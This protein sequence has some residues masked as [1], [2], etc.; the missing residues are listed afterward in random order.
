MIRSECVGIP[1]NEVLNSLY[2]GIKLLLLQPLLLLWFMFIFFDV[3]AL[4]KF[5]IQLWFRTLDFISEVVRLFRSFSFHPFFHPRHTFGILLT[6]AYLLAKKTFL[7]SVSLDVSLFSPTNA[8]CINFVYF[9][10]MILI[11]STFYVH[12]NIGSRTKCNRTR[13]VKLANLPNL[14]PSKR[15]VTSKR[16]LH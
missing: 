12:D 6:S 5:H 8:I 1:E 9:S 3:V 11:Y 2:Y 15:S 4:V 7:V 14:M 13:N 16:T 10:Y